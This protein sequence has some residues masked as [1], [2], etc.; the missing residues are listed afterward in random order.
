MPAP[1]PAA[2]LSPALCRLARGLQGALNGGGEREGLCL[3]SDGFGRLDELLSLGCMQDIGRG[4]GRAGLRRRPEHRRLG[5]ARLGAAAGGRAP[6]GV[7]PAHGLLLLGRGRRRAVALGLRGRRDPRGGRAGRG[8]GGGAATAGAGAARAAAGRGGRGGPAAALRRLLQARRGA[9][10]ARHGQRRGAGGA[11]Q[12]RGAA[13]RRL[14]RGVA[15]AAAGRGPRGGLRRPGVLRDLGPGRRAPVGPRARRAPGGA[16]GAAGAAG[17]PAVLGVPRRRR[18][19]GLAGAGHRGGGSRAPLLDADARGAR[20]P[21]VAGA[22]GPGLVARA[23]AAP[24]GPAPVRGARAPR[25]GRLRRP[26]GALPRTLQVLQPGGGLRLPALRLAAGQGR[27]LPRLRLGR[28]RRGPRALRHTPGLGPLRAGGGVRAAVEE[29]QAARSEP[30][31]GRRGPARGCPR[32][33]PSWTRGRASRGASPPAGRTGG[34]SSPPTGRA[35]RGQTASCTARGPSTATSHCT[36]GRR[37]RRQR[38]EGGAARAVAPA[39]GVGASRPLAPR[40]G[41]LARAGPPG[42]GHARGAAPLRR[43]RRRGD[44]GRRLREAERD[45]VRPEPPPADPGRRARLSRAPARPARAAG[46]AP[47]GTRDRREVPEGRPPALRAV[48][49]RPSWRRGWIWVRA[50]GK[51]TFAPLPWHAVSKTAAPAP[52]S[53]RSTAAGTAS[54][55]A[56]ASAGTTSASSADAPAAPGGWWRLLGDDRRRGPAPQPGEEGAAAGAAAAPEDNWAQ[57]SGRMADG[58]GAAAAAVGKGRTVRAGDCIQVTC[59]DDA[60]AEQGEAVFRIVSLY[61]ASEH[62][63]FARAEFLFCTDQYLQW[64]EENAGSPGAR[65]SKRVLHFCPEDESAI[66][67]AAEAGP[68]VEVTHVD[69]FV[70]LESVEEAYLQFRRRNPAARWPAEL[71]PEPL[72]EELGDPGDEELVPAELDE[73]GLAAKVVDSVGE[74]EAAREAEGPGAAAGPPGRAAVKARG[75]PPA[76]ARP[77]A[78]AASEPAGLPGGSVRPRGTAG[79]ET[80]LEA[81]AAAAAKEPAGRRPDEEMQA[82]LR[83]RLGDL[84]GR[85]GAEGDAAAEPRGAAAEGAPLKRKSLDEILAERAAKA[86]RRGPA[87]GGAAGS[88]GL[89]GAGPEREGGGSAAHLLRSLLGALTPAE[90]IEGFG[91]TDGLE[92]TP[93]KSLAASR[94]F[95]RKTARD[96]PGKLLTAHLSH[97]KQFLSTKGM[98]DAEEELPPIVNKF[99]L[100]IFLA[101]HPVSSIGEDMFRQMR[102]LSESLDLLIQGKL[103]EAM[104]MLMQ[105]FKAC[106][107]ACK[108]KHWR[109]ARWLELIPPDADMAAINIEEEELLR[110]IE[111]GELKLAEL[112]GKLKPSRTFKELKLQNPKKDGE[113]QGK[114]RQRLALLMR[115]DGPKRQAPPVQGGARKVI[116]EGEGSQDQVMLTNYQYAGTCGEEAWG[117]HSH[118]SAAQVN[119]V[120]VMREA[121]S[122]FLGGDLGRVQLPLL[123]EISTRA[124]SAYDI[125]SGTRALPLRLGELRPGRPAADVAGRLDP[126]AHVSPE[127]L[128]WLDDPSVALLPRAQWPSEVPK[129]R[130]LVDSPAEWARI[131]GHLYSL[132]IVEAIEDEQIFRADGVPVLNGAFAVEKRGVPEAGEQRQRRFIM[133]MVPA[134]SYLKIMTQDLSTLTASTSWVTVVLE[135]QRVLLWSGDDQQGAFFVWKIPRAWRSF[136]TLKGRVPGRLV[137]RPDLKTVH[138]CSAVIPMGWLLAVTLFQ[139]LHRRLG[140]RPPPAGAGLPEIDEWRRDKPLPIA[141]VGGCRSWYQFFIDDFDAPRIVNDTEGEVGV[142]SAYQKRQRASYQRNG[143]AWAERKAHLGETKVER[144]G[145]LVDGLRGPVS[146]PLMKLFETMLLGALLVTKDWVYWKTMLVLLGKL[147]RALEF[148]CVLF[149]ILNEVWKFADGTHS[150]WVNSEMTEEILSGV[151]L[152]PLAFT[153]LR[154]EVDARV[155]CSDASEDG[156]GA[157]T[158]LR[159]CPEALSKLTAAAAAGQEGRQH[160]MA[161]RLLLGEASLWR[162]WESRN[163]GLPPPAGDKIPAVLVIGLF[164]GIGGMIVSLSRL[165]TKIIGYVSSEVDPSARRVVRKRWPGLID[166]GNIQDVGT[167]HIDKLV[168]LFGGIVDVVYCGAG[169]PC[170]DLSRLM[171]GR[172]GLEGQKSALFREIPRILGLLNA[173]FPGKVRSLV[174]N[175]A[176][177]PFEDI[178]RI[179]SELQVTPY[180][181]CSSCLVPNRRPRLH[182]LSWRLLP[183][184]GYSYKDRGHFVEV[185]SD[186]AARV[187]LPWTSPGWI[188][189]GGPLPVPTLVCARPSLLQPTRPAGIARASPEAKA[190]WKKDDHRYHVG[191]YENACLLQHEAT[192]EL[193]PP[194]AEER[195]VLLGFDRGY[196]ECAVKDG[197]GSSLET[198]RCFLLGNSFSVYAVSWLLQ[199]SLVADEFQPQLWEPHALCHTGKCRAPWNDSAVYHQGDDYQYEPEAEQLV[200]HYLSIAERGGTDVRLDV[201]LPFRHRAWPRVSLEP[202]VWT[203]KVISSYRWRAGI[204]KH[205][206]ALE[207]QAAVNTIKWRLRSGTGRPR[208]MLHL[209]DSQVAAS[210]LTKGRSSSRVLRM[211]VKRWGALCWATGCY[212]ML[213]YI[214]LQRLRGSQRLSDLRVSAVTLKRYR[215]AVAEFLAFA[216]EGGFPLNSSAE[217][218][219]ALG[220]YVEDQWANEGTLSHGRYALAGCLFFAPELRTALP[221]AWSL[222][223]TWQKLAPINRA[224]PASPEMALGLAGAAVSVGQPLL[225]ALVLVTFDAMLRTKELRDLTYDDITFA[226]GGVILRL[227]ETKMGVRTGNVQFVVVRTPAAVNLL[228]VAAE[229]AQPTDHL[230]PYTYVQLQRL[231]KSLLAVA[232]IPPARWSWYSFRRGGACHDFL[233]GANL[234]RTMQRGRWSAVTSARVYIEEAVADLVDVSMSQLSKDIL[235]QL[236]LMLLNS[237]YSQ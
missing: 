159:L 93:G 65:K 228:R 54:A 67:C 79:G 166:W 69:E 221:F 210:V 136:T 160:L 120:E 231:L 117:H 230:C 26:C 20:P 8:P 75:R 123:S 151:G 212:V 225:A 2:P 76:R 39:G 86:P 216:I 137:G 47:G 219:S 190:R 134:N 102:T 204:G 15:R 73:F 234:E 28:A 182:W 43:P 121:V 179:S 83:K 87:D 126:R 213:G 175:V 155:T 91:I 68:G 116:L 22:A 74:L 208:R 202:S 218:D 64:Y 122:Y 173:A 21:G 77:P 200:R 110:K 84:K 18:G 174:E 180:R 142:G 78:A 158:S 168:Q 44:P 191:L 220:A 153:D 195:E 48:G 172:R 31:A 40:A 49:G 71:G 35:S 187:E 94:A 232:S 115:G 215:I 224:Y 97:L 133:N 193:R 217:A 46:A 13:H 124:S 111:Y 109:S 145:V 185:I 101:S 154:A 131:V 108:D 90:G 143:V 14:G 197:S 198:T 237:G 59:Y 53:G 118:Y 150:G 235:S 113:T 61:E 181:F 209:I 222:V 139:H 214:A 11:W 188:W 16:R 72:E 114:Y 51:H 176:S 99:L 189:N 10:L 63:Q 7:R 163:P 32:G 36:S 177:M 57:A 23:D 30:F 178:E 81:A 233:L 226:E 148:R 104:D 66:L 164:D 156:G 106:Q 157:C 24:D 169:S 45:P 6:G 1:A 207:I 37:G 170:Q 144:M 5:R 95:F 27:V 165:R 199:H 147:V 80:P 89:A 25:G 96:T 205:I 85:L 203:W 229:R 223:K 41:A 194:S 130:L 42:A 132:G 196:T 149:C 9:A 140:L 112:A 100:N 52:G 55:S 211:H 34:G 19:R 141:Q 127:V 128:T 167:Q 12:R 103:P 92:F 29:R 56:S 107:L 186:G 192:M 129:A 119:A 38:W 171:F 70:V 236:G 58:E 138:V 201:H 162:A 62:G 152:L 105:R 183:C 135:G 98:H 50:T 82:L 4:G 33:A 184:K 17:G 60:D 161:G 125:D 146:V 88:G 227:S 3:R 206:N